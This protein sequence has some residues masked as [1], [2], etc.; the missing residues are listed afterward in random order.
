MNILGSDDM[1]DV[2]KQHSKDPSGVSSST[3]WCIGLLTKRDADLGKHTHD[4]MDSE[5]NTDSESGN[6]RSKRQK[7]CKRKS[8]HEE[9]LTK[10]WMNLR[11]NIDL[12]IL[13]FSIEYGLNLI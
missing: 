10:L 8:W 3:L 5:S 1:Q 6:K 2:R 11:L 9:K 7:N 4:Q 12:N 13:I